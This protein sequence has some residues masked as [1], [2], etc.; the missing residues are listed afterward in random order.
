MLLL[1]GLFKRLTDDL[2]K[3]ARSLCMK[4]RID[5][6][7]NS[8]GIMSSSGR[9]IGCYDDDDDFI[10][11]IKCK[12]NL[13]IILTNTQKY[14]N[15]SSICVHIF[16]TAIFVR[17]KLKLSFKYP[18]EVTGIMMSNGLEMLEVKNI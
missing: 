9:I 2:V 4:R 7:G 15:I 3:S 11:F 16:D 8:C 12:L 5:R 6:S 1:T 13:R 14:T 17:A 18:P 10:H